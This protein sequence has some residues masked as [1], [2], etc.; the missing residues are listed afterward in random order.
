VINQVFVL[1]N[2]I[3]ELPL[4]FHEILFALFIFGGAMKNNMLNQRW[5][6]VVFLL[7]PLMSSWTFS[8]WEIQNSGVSVTLWDVCFVDSL[9]GW[10]VGDSATI[11]AT[12]DGGKTWIRQTTPVDTIGFRK[13]EFVNRQVGFVGGNRTTQL[14]YRVSYQAIL[15]RTM[16]GGMHWKES[17]LV[18]GF[19]FAFRDMD[20]F[21]NN[22]G[23]VAIDV[24]DNAG[25][26]KGMLLST[27]N[28]GQDWS[29]VME[30]E[31]DLIGAFAFWD[32][33]Y[34]YSFWAPFVD[35]FDAT[36]VY[37]TENEGVE[38]RR[39]GKIESELIRKVE[40]L[41]RDTLWA[42]GY[43]ISKSETGGKDW[44]SWRDLGVVNTGKMRFSPTDVKKLDRNTIWVIGTE[45][46]S[47]SNNPA[48]LVSTT[49]LGETWWLELKMS[50]KSFNG[51]SVVSSKHVWI[52]GGAGLILHKQLSATLVNEKQPI[53]PESFEL[54]QNYPNPF[55]PSSSYPTTTIQFSVKSQEH[56]K[57]TIYDILGR[58]IKVLLSKVIS[59]GTYLVT[60]DGRDNSSRLHVPS[61]VYFYEMQSAGF[62][63]RRKMLVTH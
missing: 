15:L 16:D 40:L 24:D 8:Q 33:K 31:P 61:G 50:N 19:D 7:I 55:S 56:I 39:V 6:S 57:I 18:F 17:N 5:L 14:P 21:D 1:R 63:V 3:L 43:A 48:I 32:D 38:W 22:K 27:S 23:M 53:P 54:E 42:G 60:W 36:S 45:W 41:S 25:T 37:V 62:T 49:D 51:L 28:G 44:V 59:P 29:I 20:F 9:Q 47:P 2:L 30:K 35:P 10:A 58:E 11:I 12:T 52:V 13:V 46:I 34:G 4:N 26:R